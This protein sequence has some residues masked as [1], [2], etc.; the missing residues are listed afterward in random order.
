MLAEI[1]Y[2][3]LEPGLPDFA[4]Q[5]VTAQPFFQGGNLALLSRTQFLEK[6]Q[7]CKLTHALT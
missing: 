1:E 3:Q 4:V 6:F 2:T 7:I 5:Y